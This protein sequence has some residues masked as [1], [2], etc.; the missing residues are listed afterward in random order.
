MSKFQSPAV[1]AECPH[2]FIKKFIERYCTP[3]DG[4]AMPKAI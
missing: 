2:Q 4:Q 3:C 1:A